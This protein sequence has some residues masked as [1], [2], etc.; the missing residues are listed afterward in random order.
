LYQQPNL[1]NL[2]MYDFLNFEYEPVKA[3]EIP[4]FLTKDWALGEKDE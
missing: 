3:D 1:G 4:N 2:N